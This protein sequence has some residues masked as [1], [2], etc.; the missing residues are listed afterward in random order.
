MCH[1]PF[2]RSDVF[3]D[4]ARDLRDDGVAKSL[5]SFESSRISREIPGG[6][7]PRPLAQGGSPESS[8]AA[9]SR[10][11]ACRS[12][13]SADVVLLF[14]LAQSVIHRL[15]GEAHIVITNQAARYARVNARHCVERQVCGEHCRFANA[16]AQDLVREICDEPARVSAGA[17]VVNHHKRRVCDVVNARADV[18][19]AAFHPRHKPMP[20][21]PDA[22]AFLREVSDGWMRIPAGAFFPKPSDALHQHRFAGAAVAEQRQP[23]PARMF[24][25]CERS[26]M[27]H[28]LCGRSFRADE[29]GV[30][31]SV[32]ITEQRVRERG[33]QLWSSQRWR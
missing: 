20:R 21:E 26:E 31:E 25:R 6:Q 27:R 22:I 17:D 9:R 3:E 10:F 16:R 33:F 13:L 23:T 19:F 5:K 32:E 18:A 8:R 14:S 15:D 12:A 2:L 11:E 28:K 1:P 7:R 29:R 4:F 30:S 24:G